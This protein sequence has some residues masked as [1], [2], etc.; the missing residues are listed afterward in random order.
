MVKRIRKELWKKSTPST[1]VKFTVVHQTQRPRIQPLPPPENGGKGKLY[2]NLLNLSLK[3]CYVS[4]LLR[5]LRTQNNSLLS[6]DLRVKGIY[7]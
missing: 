1:A 4:F 6:Q 2:R 3:F 7:S 5:H